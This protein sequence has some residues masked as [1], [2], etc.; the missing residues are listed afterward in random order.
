MRSPQTLVRPALWALLL[1]AAGCSTLDVPRA[2]NYPASDQKKVRAVHHWDVLADDVAQRIATKISDWPAGEHPIYIAPPLGSSFNQGFHK[3]LI[4]HLLERG[5]VLSTEPGAVTLHFET[6]LVQHGASVE[7]RA[8]RPYTQLAAGVAVTRNIDV[9]APSATSGIAT[10][11]PS[12]SAKRSTDYT[13]DGRSA[14]AEVLVTTFLESGGRFL[15]STA[16]IYYIERTEAALYRSA[17]LPA[18]PV[19]VKTWQ[20]VKP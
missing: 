13:V 15:A 10:G 3:L 4:G 18:P 19:P 11:L 12:D 6:Q 8:D 14:R 9:H 17:A 20:V 5:V 2:E 1:L 16:D 7:N